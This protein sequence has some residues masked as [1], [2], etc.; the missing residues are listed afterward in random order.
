MTV[1]K[2]SLSSAI[3]INMNIIIGAGLFIN[4]VELSKRAGILG[5]FSYV[6]VGLLL[7][8]LIASIA[9]LV[10][11]HPAGG[12]Y[13]YASKELSPFAGFF[14]AWSYFVGKLAATTLMVHTAVLLIQQI[15]V[16]TQWISPFVLDVGILS[17]F[18]TLNMF[19]TKTGSSIQ[20]IFLTLKS[21]PIIFTILSGCYL[22]NRT[23]VS[24]T[25]FLWEGIPSTIALV[26][27]ATIGFEAACS[28]SSH[29]K[30][31]AKNGPKAIFISY[32]LV[33]FIASIFQFLLYA[34]VGPQLALQA[35]YLATF[36][37]LLA[38][39]FPSASALRSSLEPLLY[40]A[41]ASSAL[42]GA[43]GIIYTNSWN[44]YILAQNNHLV[45]SN[46]FLQKNRYFIPFFCVLAEGFVCLLYL[47]ITRGHQLSLQQLSGLG[48]M[49]AY[50]MSVLSLLAAKY[51]KPELPIQ[52]WIPI[53]GLCNCLVLISLCVYNFTISGLTP[54]YLFMTLVFCGV[55]MY[56]YKKHT[57]KKTITTKR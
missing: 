7:L 5:A 47:S 42:G 55:L 4:T 56:H 51:N 1:H 27:Y 39:L 6:I 14:S 12:F 49:I 23:N 16:S 18:I 33:I 46:F 26:L 3:L 15:L 24:S 41:I 38:H 9:T 36:P 54:L 50:T 52:W 53:L 13:A 21:I 31:A 8:P 57:Y 34:S 32:G 45:K 22:F 2:L 37:T 44:L 30:D 48:C 35:D 11:L 19:N 17:L 40:L 10:S 28:L 43:Y 25:Y 20:R 29:I